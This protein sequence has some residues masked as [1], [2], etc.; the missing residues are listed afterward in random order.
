[1]RRCARGGANIGGEAGFGYTLID[2]GSLQPCTFNRIEIEA[3]TLGLAQVRQMG[4]PALGA[5]ANA[6]LA[7]VAATLPPAGQQ[8]LLHGVSRVHQCSNPERCSPPEAD[9][10]LLR[11]GCWREEA[12]EI[13]YTDR[14]GSTTHRTIWPLAIVYLDQILM[15]LAR[16]CFRDDFRMFRVDRITLVTHTEITF[17]PRRVK[18][19]GIYLT[20]LHA[21]TQDGRP[22]LER[23]SSG[24]PSSN[25]TSA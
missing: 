13:E 1:M 21:N 19:L 23:L 14:H 15:V 24:L 11:Q 6:V 17:R 5:A 3:L 2:D 12:L 7:K 25:I 4:D 20:Q 16:C 8:H 18:L 9:M 10:N 22:P